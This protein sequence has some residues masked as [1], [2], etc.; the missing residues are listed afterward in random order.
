MPTPE[1]HQDGELAFS[2]LNEKGKELSPSQVRAQVL[3]QHQLV[4]AGLTR[5]T[6]LIPQVLAGD[7]EAVLNLKAQVARFLVNLDRHMT[8]EETVLGPCLLDVDPLRPARLNQLQ[9]DHDQQRHLLRTFAS[10]PGDDPQ[11]LADRVLLLAVSL[12]TD[13]ETEEREILD[14]RILRDDTISIDQSSG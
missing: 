13:M 6:E 1:K 7:P 12:T 5:L 4:R 10:A 3:A 14:P 9:A 2:T 8:F 11:A